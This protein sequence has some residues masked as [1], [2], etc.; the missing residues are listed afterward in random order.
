M[1]KYSI[2]YIGNGMIY[3]RHGKKHRINSPAI[4]YTDSDRW[5]FQYGIIIKT[6]L[7]EQYV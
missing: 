2:I 7:S 1:L 6:E 4:I 3:Y 5:W